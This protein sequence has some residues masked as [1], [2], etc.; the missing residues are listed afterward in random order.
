MA[1]DLRS[2]K[3]APGSPSADAGAGIAQPSRHRSLLRSLERP[4]HP[5]AWACGLGALGLALT[6]GAPLLV[7]VCFG[8]IF[9]AAVFYLSPGDAT[10]VLSLAL[11]ALFIIPQRFV[12]EP[13]GAAGTPAIMLGVAAFT[14]WAVSRMNGTSPGANGYNPTRIG[15]VILL[16]D[17]RRLRSGVLPAADDHRVVQRRPDAHH[18]DRLLG[19]P[20][21]VRRRRAEPRAPR[22]AAPPPHLG[23]LVHGVRRAAAVLHPPTHRPRPVAPAAGTL[24]QRTRLA[25]QPGELLPGRLLP[26]GGDGA[27]PHRVRRRGG[28]HPAHRHPLRLRR[29]PTW[30]ARP[31]DPGGEHGLRHAAGAVPLRVPRRWP[32]RPSASCRPCRP[33]A[34]STLRGR[35]GR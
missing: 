29:H 18:L 2:P 11:G 31:L 13:L 7:A 17:A 24:F 4:L 3:R 19:L 14:W 22:R 23:R 32:W 15:L 6:V 27:A 34:A 1:T 26:G 21:A 10:T 25:D 12:F 33:P 8:A 30:G 35:R 9:L 20:P 5:W 28:S 16:R